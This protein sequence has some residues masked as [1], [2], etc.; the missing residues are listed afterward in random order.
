MTNKN[1]IEAVL[2]DLDGTLLDTAPDLTTAINA[3][4]NY[5]GRP[6]IALT[7]MRPLISFGTRYFIEHLLRLSPTHRLFNFITYQMLCAYQQVMTAKTTLFPG[8][9]T[10]LNYL[11]KN[12]IPWGIITNKA[13]WLARPLIAHFPEFA[14]SR[15]LIGGDSLPQKKPDPLPLSYACQ[16]LHQAPERTLYV[17]DA[18]NDILSA[19]RANLISVAAAY[20]YIPPNHPASYWEADI[21]IKRPE[22][23]IE[24]VLEPH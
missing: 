5:Y 7:D 1:S 23:L 21:I 10:V 19:K 14:Q 24:A 11:N 4:L 17:G 18:R 6:A 16:L 3:V 2:F 22:E 9:K 13:E 12:N 8:I 15:C 20:G